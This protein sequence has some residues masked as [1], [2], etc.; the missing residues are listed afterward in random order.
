MY[1][2]SK[3][4][5]DRFYFVT[6]LPPNVAPTVLTVTPAVNPRLDLNYDINFFTLKKSNHLKLN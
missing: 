2:R 3:K 4:L 1:H 5:H 6:S